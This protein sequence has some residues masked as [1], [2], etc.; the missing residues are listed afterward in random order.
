MEKQEYIDQ[1]TE[2]GYEVVEQMP[3]VLWVQGLGLQ[4]S[5]HLDDPDSWLDELLDPEAHAKRI[6]TFENPERL[7]PESD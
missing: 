7:I 2:L 3:G 4:S 5:F 1:L 6:E